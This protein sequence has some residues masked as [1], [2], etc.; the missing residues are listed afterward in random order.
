M[1]AP[2]PLTYSNLTDPPSPHR[3][4][5]EKTGKKQPSGPSTSV[6]IS[7]YKCLANVPQN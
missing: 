2:R 4:D 1:Q 3:S 6:Y 5:S 7:V